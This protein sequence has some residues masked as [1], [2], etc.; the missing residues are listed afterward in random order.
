MIRLLVMFV[1]FFGLLGCDQPVAEKENNAKEVTLGDAVLSIP[2]NYFLSV[3]SALIPEEG[4]DENSGVLIGVPYEDVG[5]PPESVAGLPQRLTILMYPFS[6]QVN[7]S[8]LKAWNGTGRFDD[9]IVEFDEQVGLYRVYPKIAHP[10][11]WEYFKKSPLD[12]GD[13]VTS[14]VAGCRLGQLAENGNDLKNVFC[15]VSS[16]YKTIDSEISLRGD[17]IKNLGS[18]KDEYHRLLSSWE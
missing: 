16:R 11:S 8:A 14:W 15:S 3:S 6:D 12:G 7:P 18:I 2:H 9:R 10:R 13:Y 1:L 4:M 17:H 5:L